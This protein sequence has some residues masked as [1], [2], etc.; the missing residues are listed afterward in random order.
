MNKSR[1][2]GG[3]GRDSQ[4][5][6]REGT[7]AISSRASERRP[8]ECRVEAFYSSCMRGQIDKKKSPY[9]KTLDKKRRRGILERKE[10]VSP[11][12]YRHVHIAFPVWQW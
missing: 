8:R 12:L 9:Y 10:T 5:R 6:E 4:E 11:F 2:K 3:G 7:C 1:S